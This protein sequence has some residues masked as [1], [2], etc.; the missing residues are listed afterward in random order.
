MGQRI[1]KLIFILV[2]ALIAKILQVILGK[3]SKKQKRL[4]QDGKIV[5]KMSGSGGYVMLAL[6]IVMFAFITFFVWM[7]LSTDPMAWEEA[8]GLMILCEGMGVLI[9]LAGIWVCYIIHARAI[10]IDWEKITVCK[11]FKA[12][13]EIPWET[14]GSIEM[15]DAQ[16]ILY[17]RNRQIRLK[18]NAQLNNY[19][20]FY[21]VAKAKLEANAGEIKWQ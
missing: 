16:S 9:L 13:E 11:P 3:K 20:R 17:D 6:G 12:D 14:I 7:A 21:Q 4:E 15:Q 1:Y 18:V 5:M 19:A 10:I 8:G 2:I